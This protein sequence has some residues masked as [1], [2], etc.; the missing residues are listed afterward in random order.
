MN[1]TEHLVGDL[2]RL[3]EHLGLDRW[4]LTGGSWGRTLALAYA[5]RHPHRVTE[6]VL[7]EAMSRFAP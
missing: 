6:I 5:Q 4:M 7:R 1:T 3:R 2:E